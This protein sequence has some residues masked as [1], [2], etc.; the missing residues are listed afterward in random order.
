MGYVV[1]RPPLTGRPP[2]DRRRL[3]A[4]VILVLVG[5]ALLVV[6][7]FLPWYTEWSRLCGLTRSASQSASGA[8]GWRFD[9]L[10]LAVATS[11]AAL[12]GT[13]RRVLTVG[14]ALPLPFLA[15]FWLSNSNLP[16][17]SVTCPTGTTPS[18][19]L[20][21][22]GPGTGVGAYLGV[23]AAFVVLAG[24]VAHSVMAS[25]EERALSESWPLESGPASA[26]AGDDAGSSSVRRLTLV[27]AG[28]LA[29]A[30]ATLVLC[31]LAQIGVAIDTAP[32]FTGCRQVPVSA[33]RSIPTTTPPTPPTTARP[34]SPSPPAGFRVRA[35]LEVRGTS[36]LSS[37][38]NWWV[39][40]VTVGGG[41]I[42]GVGTFL[43]VRRRGR[44]R[45]GPS[46][47]TAF[48]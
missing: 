41:T 20:P 10:G 39:I 12:F 44:P 2:S 11:M 28:A 46:P 9:L 16:G 43:L 31:T 15:L 27:L 48:H 1:R 4:G 45:S 19:L 47:A 33:P 14:L 35:T 8:G 17:Q 21:A 34:P 6:S 25:H 24:A 40:P 5:S 22:G 29:G 3:D 13:A 18:S 36:C 7:F 38:T 32:T 30:L 42:G 37:S 23:A 26:T